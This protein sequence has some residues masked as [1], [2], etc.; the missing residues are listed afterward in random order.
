MLMVTMLC[1][2]VVVCLIL[3]ANVFCFFFLDILYRLSESAISSMLWFSFFFRLW[4]TAYQK[5]D[6]STLIDGASVDVVLVFS[7]LMV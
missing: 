1:N 5:D 6:T 4:F 3:V 7:S 2:Y